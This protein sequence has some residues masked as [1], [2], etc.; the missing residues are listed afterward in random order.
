MGEHY[1]LFILSTYDLICLGRE[2]KRVVLQGLIWYTTVI[3]YIC[4]LEV[5]KSKGKNFINHLV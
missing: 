5:M 4:L 2:N 3:F 1:I